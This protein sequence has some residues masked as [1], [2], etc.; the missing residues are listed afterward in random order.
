MISL[1]I[2]Q[3]VGWEKSDPTTKQVLQLGDPT[4]N[5]TSMQVPHFKG[6]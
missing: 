6:D 5:V 1:V 3:S 4:P 2:V